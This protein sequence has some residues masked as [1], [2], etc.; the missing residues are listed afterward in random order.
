VY[1]DGW[2]FGSAVVTLITVFTPSVSSLFRLDDAFSLPRKSPRQT[3]DT[4]GVH[5]RS[6]PEGTKKEE[7]GKRRRKKEKKEDGFVRGESVI[8]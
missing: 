5:T 2:Q 8:D 1:D 6:S 3:S 7:E 4:S